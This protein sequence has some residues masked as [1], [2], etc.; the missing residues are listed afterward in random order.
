M[1][2][3]VADELDLMG[4]GVKVTNCYVNID[5]ITIKKSNIPDFKYEINATE[6]IYINK[7]KRDN[8][9]TC[10]IS[11]KRVGYTSNVLSNIHE[12]LYTKVKTGY[13]SY[14]DEL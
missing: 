6:Q 3:T 13:T 4:N 14:T 8:D 11:T 2:I 1:G 12:E 7:S 9:N 10:I 5:M